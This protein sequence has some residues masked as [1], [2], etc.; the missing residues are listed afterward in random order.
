MSTAGLQIFDSKGK[1][2]LDSSVGVIKKLGTFQ[3]EY[4]A[5]SFTDKNIIGKKIAFWVEKIEQTKGGQLLSVAYP[6]GLT[7][8]TSTGVISWDFSST[9]LDNV[10]VSYARYRIT[11]GYGWY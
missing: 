1:L 2:I 9:R 4:T 7:A 11:W 6:R 3:T 10:F 8:D 5:S